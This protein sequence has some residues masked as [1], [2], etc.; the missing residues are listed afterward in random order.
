MSNKTHFGFEEVDINQKAKKVGDVFHSVAEEYD[1][2]NDV[3]SFGMHRLWKRMLLELSGLSENAI[4]L[5]IASGTGDIPKLI[6]QKFPSSHIHVTDINESMLTLGKERSINENFYQNC[7]FALASGEKL[8]YQDQMFD[9]VTIGFGLRNFTD[10]QAG[11][12]EMKRVLRPGGI[13]LILEFSKPT[14][15]LFSKIYDWYSFNVIPRLGSLFVDDADSYKY[16][17]ESIRMHPAQEELKLMVIEA[18]FEKCKFYNLVN[19][20]VAIH[21]AN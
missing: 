19:G 8:P 14:N 21:Q 3:M 6:S 9:L 13:L 4:A 16:L 11:L 15:S 17:A 12:R 18:G 10:K 7:S 20:V 1:L 2:M 5:D